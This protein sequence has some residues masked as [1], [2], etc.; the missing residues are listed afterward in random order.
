MVVEDV[1]SAQGEFVAHVAG[2]GERE[3]PVIPV[4]SR[5]RSWREVRKRRGWKIWS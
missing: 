1:G 3:F 2:A 4:M 5:L